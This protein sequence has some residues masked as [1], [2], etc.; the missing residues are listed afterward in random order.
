M[1]S[2]DKPARIAQC[3]ANIDAVLR[4]YGL[5]PIEIL[6]AQTDRITAF[7]ADGFAAAV[8]RA[9]FRTGPHAGDPAFRSW[10]LVGNHGTTAFRGWRE[11]VPRCSLQIV[12]HEGRIFEMDVDLI[13]PGYRD[14][15]SIVGHGIETLWPGKTNPFRV[16]DGLRKRG[17]LA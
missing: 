4:F 3:R 1:I 2:A 14:L 9:I 5:P 11:D 7:A 13:N 8:S 17:I 16:R 15:V 12:E 10:G 6:T